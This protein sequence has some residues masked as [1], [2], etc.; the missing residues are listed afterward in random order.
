VFGATGWSRR[1]QLAVTDE[2]QLQPVSQWQPRV[3][4][5][6]SYKDRSGR[7]RTPTWFFDNPPRAGSASITIA[8][9][10]RKFQ[11]EI[12]AGLIQFIA[13][14]ASIGARPQMGFGVI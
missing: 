7:D 8:A 12:I 4:A 11:A 3:T 2:I 5:S 1:F 6:R 9:T 14:W 13:D 10:N